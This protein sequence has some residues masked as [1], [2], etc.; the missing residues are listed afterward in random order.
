MID[1]KY[2]RHFRPSTKS[3]TKP[4]HYTASNKTASAKSKA[5]EKPMAPPSQMPSN[6][7]VTTARSFG[8]SVTLLL[9]NKATTTADQDTKLANIASST[10]VPAMPSTS[11][12][13][14]AAILQALRQTAPALAMLTAI[15]TRATTMRA[16]NNASV[17]KD[18]APGNIN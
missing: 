10:T 6:R 11:Q 14:L 16:A 12:K 17:T 1:R 8:K 4:L 5:K 7:L 18:A 15:K 2:I 9:P 3:K 13:T